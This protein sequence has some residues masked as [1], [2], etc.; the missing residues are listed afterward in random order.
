MLIKKSNPSVRK[1]I[2]HGYIAKISNEI[3][4]IVNFKYVN[5][6][7]LYMGKPTKLKFPL[8]YSY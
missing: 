5:P 2:T 1:N 3:V 8:L 4:I 7:N 6:I